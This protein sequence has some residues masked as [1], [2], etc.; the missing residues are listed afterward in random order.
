MNIS[1]IHIFGFRIKFC[2]KIWRDIYIYIYILED[3]HTSNYSISNRASR[4]KTNNL[5]IPKPISSVPESMH[6]LSKYLLPNPEGIPIP[7]TDQILVDPVA[8]RLR[9]D[10]EAKVH[11]VYQYGPNILAKSMNDRILRGITLFTRRRRSNASLKKESISGPPI[12]SPAIGSRTVAM[13]A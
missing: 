8:A 11:R 10:E 7:A 1:R 4:F 3:E 12:V 2:K 5:L 9:I 13:A 6:S